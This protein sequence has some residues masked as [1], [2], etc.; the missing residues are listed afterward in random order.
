ML[1]WGFNFISLKVLYPVMEPGAILFWRYFLMGGILVAICKLTGNSLQIPKEHRWRILFA[2]MNSMGIYMIMFMEGVKLTYAAEAAIILASNPVIV[3]VWMMLLKMEP[4]SYGKV[5]GG[6]VALVGVALVVLGRPGIVAGSKEASARLLGDL[7]MFIG[8]MSWSAS[9]VLCKPISNQIKPLPLFTMSM[10]GGLPVVFLYG[11]GPAL[12]VHWSEI[13]PW[14][15]INFGQVLFGSGVV[16]MVFYY[17]GIAQLPASVA[18]MYQFL[19]PIL[20][21]VFGAIVLHEH[22]AWVQACGLAV[23]IV[24]V[25]VAMGLIRLARVKTPALIEAIDDASV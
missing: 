15:A 1:F 11:I 12:R 24:G 10:L 7:L 13:T 20:A 25:S 18:T 9:V 4:K 3:A 17:K 5:L 23:L 14:Q 8:A 22:L 16:G 6:L 19:V 2:G 21:T